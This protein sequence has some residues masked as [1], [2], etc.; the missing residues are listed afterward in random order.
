MDINKFGTIAPG[1]IAAISDKEHAFVPD[2]LP[3]KW[4]FPAAL[5]P[6]LADAKSKVALLEGVGRTLPNPAILLQPLASREAIQSS[7]LEGTY[8]SPRELLLF[9]ID[10]QE[11]RPSEERVND[12]REVFN[13]RK[14]LTHAI[15]SQLPLSL[16]LIREIHRILLSAVRGKDRAPGEFRR[17][18]VAIGTNKRFVPPPADSLSECLSAFEKYLHAS[19][20]YDPLVDCFITHYQ[21]ETIHPF[22]D[23]NGRVGRLLLAVMIQHRCELSKTWLYLSEFFEKNRDEYCERL[24]DVSAKGDWE[25]WISFCLRG[26]VEQATATVQRCDRLRS[27]RDKY[28]QK[29][30]DV[31]GSVRLNQIVE[32]LF[33]SPFVQV[34]VMSKQ[35]KVTYPTA[36]ADMDR[37]VRAKILKPLKNATQKTFY[38]PEVYEA[39]YADIGPA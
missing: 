16:R 18:Q 27:I 3:P 32:N 17:I 23:G 28:M 14:A 31:G 36:K 1:R 8:A 37:L 2:P 21:F 6:L 7:R 24:F 29:L 25:G 35:L 5:W 9:E 26:T 19:S 15:N 33:H 10:P 30:T 13:Y 39:A 4:E 12:R 20:A 22:I 34:A 11:G 38:A